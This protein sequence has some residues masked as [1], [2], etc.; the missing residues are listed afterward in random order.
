LIS[1]PS[2]DAHV[3]CAQQGNFAVMFLNFCCHALSYRNAYALCLLATVLMM[4]PQHALSHDAT[5]TPAPAVIWSIDPT[6]VDVALIEAIARF[7][8]LSVV[9]EH[10]DELAP[11]PALIERDLAMSPGATFM[12]PKSLQ[13]FAL[14]S[15]ELVDVEFASS[16]ALSILVSAPGAAAPGLYSWAVTSISPKK[17]CDIAAPSFF[18]FDRKVVIERHRGSPSR[19]RT[20]DPLDCNRIADF[21]VMGRVLDVDAQ[22]DRIAAAVRLSESQIALQLFDISGAL[23]ATAPIGRNV[24]MGFSPDGR[25][26]LNFDLSD[27]GPR[28]WSVP[29]LT[30]VS[31]PRWL[32]DAEVTFVP[33]SNFVKRYDAGK[34]TIS[35]WP[36]GTALHSVKAGRNLR[37]RQLS[38]NGN[39]GILHEYARGSDRLDWIDFSTGLKTPL[40][41]G[42]I[43]NAALSS[44]VR[45]AAW[46][47]R[48]GATSEVWVQRAIAP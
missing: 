44:D 14:Q 48:K 27:A 28:A 30:N 31:L 42:S 37:L 26:I 40:A 23:L 25:M 15:R 8:A 6:V 11:T 2:S 16:G 35:R 19:I 1:Q 9:T 32:S 3:D 10:V 41:A 47:L 43:D 36:L 18:S 33:G 39:I 4:L 7:T 12:S 22:G 17:L 20:Y 34:L 21:E 13:S 38:A 29:K 45:W 46:T 24:E 5:T